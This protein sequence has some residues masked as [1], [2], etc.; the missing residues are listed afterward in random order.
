MAFF[1]KLKLDKIMSEKCMVTPNFLLEYQALCHA[2]LFISIGREA[3]VQEEAHLKY[4]KPRKK[5]PQ[6]LKKRRTYMYTQ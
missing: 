6:Y 2:K 1:P 3:C 5:N 4:F